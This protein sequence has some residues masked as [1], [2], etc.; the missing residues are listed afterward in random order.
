[1]KSGHLC[2]SL[3]DKGADGHHS[4]PWRHRVSDSAAPGSTASLRAANQHRVLGVLRDDAGVFTQ[5]ELARATGLAPATVSNIVRDLSERGP[6]RVR[7]RQRTPRGRRTPLAQRR[8]GRRRRLRA[9]PC[10]GGGGRPVRPG[11]RG[12]PQAVAGGTAPRRRAGG[13]EGDARGPVL[14]RRPVARRR[15]RAARPDR[16]GRGPV[17]GDLPRL[18]RR[19][20]AAGGRADLRR[21]GARRE[22]RQ[23]RCPRRAPGGGRARTRQQRVREDLLRRRRRHHRRQRAVPRRQ[24]DGR[25]DRSPDARRPGTRC[26]GAASA[27]AWRRSSR[28]PSSR[29]RWRP[30]CPEPTTSTPCSPPHA[31][32]TSPRA[33]P[34][35]RPDCTSAAGWPAW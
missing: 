20:R 8:R 32:A 13:R 1:M 5:A 15:A 14:R 17:V 2:S 21:A 7:A 31:T 3:D 12:V 18:G 29:G 26:A 10:R 22:R 30:P 28:R 16:G 25:R 34:W 23:P 9:Q 35:R 6:G 24:R 4:A 27:A 33:G 11:D 19:E